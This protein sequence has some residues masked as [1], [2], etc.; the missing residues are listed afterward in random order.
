MKHLIYLCIA[1]LPASIWAQCDRWQQAISYEIKA[2]VNVKKNQYKGKQKVLYTNNSPDTLDQIFYHLYFNAFQ[3]GSMMDVRSQ[4]LPDPDRRVGDRISELKDD[5]VGYIKVQE[6]ELN[7]VEQ[8]FVT[9]GTIL[10]VRLTEGILPG[11]T[12]EL[13][14][15]YEAQV[16]LQIRRSGRD[17]A[18]G[19]RLSMSQWYPKVVEY[20]YQ[21]WHANPYVGRE[22]HGVWGDFDVEITIDADYIMGATGTLVNAQDIGYGYHTSAVDIGRKKKLTW[23]WKAENVHDFVWAADPDYV[24]TTYQT[25]AGVLIHCLYQPGE[26]TTENWTVLPQ[27]LDRALTYMNEHYGK[28]PYPSYAIIQGGDGGMEYPMATLITGERSIGSLVGV[29]IHEW[30]H[31]WYQMVLATNEALYP[32]MDEGFTSFASAEVMNYL[33]QEQ[34]IPGEAVDNPTLGSVMGYSGFAMTGYEEPLSTHADHYMTNQAYGIASYVKGQVLLVQLK[35][36]MGDAAFYQGLLD[37]YHTWQFKHPNINDFIRVM[38]RAGKVEL[39]WFKEYWVNTTHTIDYAVDT[40]YSSKKGTMIDLRR[41]GLLPMPSE[42]TVELMDGTE[43]VYYMPLRV[44]RGSKSF[45]DTE[46]TQLADWPW[47]HPTRQITVDAKLADIRTVTI[48]ADKN[49]ADVDRS[50]NVWPRPVEE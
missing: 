47:T 8:S 16:P 4:N 18:E 19:V 26:A 36:I 31:S 5:E 32:Y 2:D 39:D 46:V 42:V 45:N 25:E 10:E 28:Y 12:V 7:G 33:R 41:I 15:E 24:H 29:S 14:M 37:Y 22:F 30:M 40:I 34:L 6:L 43:Y 27:I 35:Y 20:D 21:G 50:N 1:L 13:E 48:G 44:M 49:L 17:N 3:P 11:A 38:E 9:E 23:H